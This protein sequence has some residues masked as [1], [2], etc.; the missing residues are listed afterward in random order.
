MAIFP[1]RGVLISLSGID[2]SGKTTQVNLLEER[3]R[4]S[5]P[6]LI[7][8]W[9]RWRALSSLPLL[10]I[11]LRRGYA[12]VHSTSSIGFVETRIPE[13]SGLASLWCFL[14][15]LDNLMK[16]GVK[17]IVPLM[18]GYTV[19]SDRYTLDLLVEGMADLHDPSTSRRLGYRL[20]RLLPRPKVAFFIDV[21]AEVAFSRKPDL[22]SL[23]HFV[24][25]VRLYR[26]LRPTTEAQLLNGTGIPET[27]HQ[28]IWD[29]VSSAL[30]TKEGGY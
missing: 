2:G 14:T 25:R 18:L 23:S 20:V 28:Q 26:E 9:S 21:S 29:K 30:A 10:T 11:L 24:E 3:L 15:Q 22:P 27:I 13:R 7:R 17:V 16:T 8:I 6:R 4:K 1:R 12:Q 19:L 5:Q